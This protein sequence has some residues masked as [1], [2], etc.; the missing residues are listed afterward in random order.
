MLER[1]VSLNST[2]NKKRKECQKKG[3]NKE[4]CKQRVAEK[5]KLIKHKTGRSDVG[6]RKCH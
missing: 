5:L 1:N 6:K 4:F 3:G 2:I